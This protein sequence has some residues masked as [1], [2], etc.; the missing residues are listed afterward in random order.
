MRLVSDDLNKVTATAATYANPHQ[1]AEFCLGM[2][3]WVLRDRHLRGVRA[4][5]IAWMIVEVAV[6]AGAWLWLTV[7]FAPAAARF[8]LPLL[9]LWVGT[10]GS[11][12]VFAILIVTFAGGHGGTGRLLSTALL[13]WLGEIRF[14]IYM[15]HQILFKLLNWNFGIGS[16]LVFFPILIVVF[17]HLFEQPGRALSCPVNCSRPAC[18]SRAEQRRLR[19]F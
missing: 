9:S 14:A 6:L 3:L 5:V 4:G 10:S 17:H 8:P 18:S 1:R 2:A 15:V 19:G 16:E 13:V 11:C 12:W 7:L